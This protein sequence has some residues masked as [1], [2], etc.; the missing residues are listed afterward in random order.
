MPMERR[1]GIILALCASIG[2]RVWGADLARE[3]DVRK[4]QDWFAHCWETRDAIC[5]AT[6]LAP[7]FTWVFR[8]GREVDRATFL[9]TIMDGKN[10]SSTFLGGKDAVVQFYG[11]VALLTFAGE[12]PPTI[13]TLV[14]FH[15]DSQGWQLVRGQGTLQATTR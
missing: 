11:P 8:N 2:V 3:A 12:N 4:A 14:W 5:M 6:L 13:L 1:V 9:A 15:S 7:D 10:I